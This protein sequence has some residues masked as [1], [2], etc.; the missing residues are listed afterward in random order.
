MAEKF[1]IKRQEYSN[2]TFRFPVELL[3]KLNELASNKNLSL[4]QIVVQ[5]CEYALKNLDDEG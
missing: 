3:E 5:C 4:N 1:R 2:R